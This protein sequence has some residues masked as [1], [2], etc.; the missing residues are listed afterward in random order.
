[1]NFQSLTNQIKK[2][3]YEV[4]KSLALT[5]TQTLDH[6]SKKAGYQSWFALNQKENADIHKQLMEALRYQ[7]ASQIRFEGDYFLS[8]LSEFSERKYQ[9]KNPSHFE[10]NIKPL[11][12]FLIANKKTIKKQV[13]GCSDDGVG[14]VEWGDYVCCYWYVRNNPEDMS[15]WDS[16]DAILCLTDIVPRLK[17]LTAKQSKLPE[18]TLEDFKK[19]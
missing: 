12:D 14:K 7:V 4:K 18:Y 11:Y 16:F 9:F 17:E 5:Y 8:D 1:M 13:D 2:E 10:E 3:A 19:A 6:L 15:E